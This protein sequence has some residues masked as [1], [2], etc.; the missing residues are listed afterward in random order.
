MRRGTH[1]CRLLMQAAAFRLQRTSQYTWI[2]NPTFRHLL[3]IV[4]L[5]S[6]SDFSYELTLEEH[7]ESEVADLVGA[8]QIHTLRLGSHDAPAS[9]EYLVHMMAWTNLI[10]GRT[11]TELRRL[12]LLN[13][14]DACSHNYLLDCDSLEELVLRN[15]RNT[16]DDQ[17]L[18]P[19]VRHILSSSPLKKLVL[20]S[21]EHA[22]TV[23][24]LVGQTLEHLEINYVD[25]LT[26]L[27]LKPHFRHLVLD[28]RHCVVRVPFIPRNIPQSIRC[29]EIRCRSQDLA[30]VCGR[31]DSDQE[32]RSSN[33]R[34]LT[35][36]CEDKRGAW[37]RP[38]NI[39]KLSI[40]CADWGVALDII[41]GDE[42]VIKGGR[43]HPSIPEEC[44]DCIS[45]TD[46][47]SS[48]EVKSDG[49]ERGLAH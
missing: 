28:S 20:I 37:T 32:W 42:A 15:H 7:D 40:R 27:G 35:I 38:R 47:A 13:I 33:L 31:L 19:S 30:D 45:E 39:A 18:H 11:S 48:D 26:A 1:A 29:L 49:N 22:T 23:L 16:F 25:D 17:D 34:Q 36:S 9:H 4:E 41:A 5:L 3:D 44:A 6:F 43:L 2:S 24:A 21:V 8:K 46:S 10:G 14:N 12:H